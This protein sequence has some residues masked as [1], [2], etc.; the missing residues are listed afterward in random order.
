MVGRPARD[1]HFVKDILRAPS[2][3]KEDSCVLWAT[4]SF[5]YTY[6]SIIY[7]S[8]YYLHNHPFLFNANI[9]TYSAGVVLVFLY[10]GR[11]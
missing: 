4:V 6:L 8:A 1:G 2:G 5:S 9:Q 11:S 3:E 7:L 10:S